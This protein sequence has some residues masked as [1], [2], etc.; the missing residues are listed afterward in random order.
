MF[1]ITSNG[2]YNNIIC[3]VQYYDV[4]TY[5]I[6]GDGHP[7]YLYWVLTNHK[8]NIFKYYMGQETQIVYDGYWI[9]LYKENLTLL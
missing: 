8:H 1:D 2:Y 6:I 4:I 3:V 5:Y 9:Q 7:A